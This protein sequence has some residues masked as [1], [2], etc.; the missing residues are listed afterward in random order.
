M[1]TVAIDTLLSGGKTKSWI[2]LVCSSFNIFRN[3][4]RF[5]GSC[6]ACVSGVSRET[7]SMEFIT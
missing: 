4:L 7:M 5:H 2:S 1:Q 3:P 6:R